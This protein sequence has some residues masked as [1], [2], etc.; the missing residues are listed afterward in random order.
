[1]ALY[2]EFS[3]ATGVQVFLCD[4]QGP[5]Q[6]KSNENANGLLRQYIP[7]GADL[8]VHSQAELNRVARELNERPRETL[9][10][11][12]PM[13]ETE[14]GYCVDPLTSP[15]VRRFIG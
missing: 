14:R 10:W 5:W 7:K 1:M 11:M 8:S 2:R 4:P 6:R 9:D 15:T 3:V 13:G 12:T